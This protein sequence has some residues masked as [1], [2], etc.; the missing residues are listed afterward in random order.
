M[1]E[2]PASVGVL[3]VTGTLLDIIGDSVDPDARPDALAPIASVTIT[4]DA[5]TPLV[6]IAEETMLTL[7]TIEA[8]FDAAGSLVA[9]A[10][11]KSGAPGSE[12]EIRLVAPVQAAINHVGWRWIFTVRPLAPMDFQEFTIFV[13][14]EAGQTVDLSSAVLAGQ[15]ASLT[16]QPMVWVQSGTALPAG[17]RPGEFVLDTDDNQLYFYG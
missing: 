17:I 12:T 11:G 3:T 15:V 9:P 1:P 10:D 6:A 5:P 2:L 8:T 4:N 7:D 13:S 14:G 16:S